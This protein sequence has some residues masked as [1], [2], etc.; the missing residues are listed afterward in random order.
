[1]TEFEKKR[2]QLE[3][4]IETCPMM[5]DKVI[6]T[7]NL[8]LS[9]QMDVLIAELRSLAT[10]KEEKTSFNHKWKGK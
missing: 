4:Q 10:K 9:E 3:K 5:R 1:M 7:S 2:K 6:I 8:L